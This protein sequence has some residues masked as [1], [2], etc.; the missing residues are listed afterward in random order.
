[1]VESVFDVLG[2]DEPVDGVWDH[3]VLPFDNL[4]LR[5]VV[6]EDDVDHVDVQL[7]LR[8]VVD[9]LELLV[10]RALLV[11]AVELT[12]ELTLVTGGSRRRPRSRCL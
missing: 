2:Q 11:V 5:L 7:E 6:V 9:Q 8:L 1:M 3:E 4:H 12:L 10:A